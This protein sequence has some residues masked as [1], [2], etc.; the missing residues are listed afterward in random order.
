MLKV[1][2]KYPIT[3]QS[4]TDKITSLGEK[5]LVAD[6]PD[7]D[8]SLY[9]LETSTYKRYILW[10]RGRYFMTY[11]RITAASAQ[12]LELRLHGRGLLSIDTS[13]S[14]PVAHWE[15]TEQTAT[16]PVSGTEDSD[17]QL[18]AYPGLTT[19]NLTASEAFDFN[20]DSG[21][22]NTI[23]AS[24]YRIHDVLKLQTTSD[25][26]G[27]PVLYW[28]IN[29]RLTNPA[30]DTTT[31]RPTVTWDETSAPDPDGWKVTVEYTH[32]EENESYDFTDTWWFPLD[33]EDS[34]N[35]IKPQNGF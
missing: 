22:L 24:P 30:P 20:I 2:G 18:Y 27:M 29:R 6:S 31:K 4:S 8:A 5:T 34:T 19:S 16:G 35:G 33:A 28:P 13:T 9:V 21:E 10:A 23:E 25:Q 3:L 15:Y 14:Y 26:S 11:D 7:M 17:I 12:P 32:D 1:N